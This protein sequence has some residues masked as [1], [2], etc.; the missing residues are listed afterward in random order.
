MNSHIISGAYFPDSPEVAL[1][2][3]DHSV[4]ALDRLHVEG[5]TVGIR[6]SFLHQD[7]IIHTHL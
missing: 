5:S 6:H 4:L 1:A 3:D 7:K 2:R